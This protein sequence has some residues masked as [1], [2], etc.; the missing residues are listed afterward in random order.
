M[1]YLS[2]VILYLA[3]VSISLVQVLVELSN[4]SYAQ[5][6]ASD[7]NNVSWQGRAPI[8]SLELLLDQADLG[9]SSL[10]IVIKAT[11]FRSGNI[12]RDADA[13]RVVFEVREYPDIIFES[14]RV[15]AQGA[16][17][18]GLQEIQLT[19]NLSMHGVTKSLTLKVELELEDT[20][21]RATGTFQVLL[22]DFAMRR[23]SLFG[24]TVN[25]EVNIIFD[26]RGSLQSE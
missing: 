5:Y 9:N 11:E 18:K 6:E 12:I 1:R 3:V 20:V 24:N 13:R 16:L 22:S 19:G 15:T 14:T 10:R 8:D 23:P 2:G 7:S 26:I 4:E 21:L 25:D 17:Q